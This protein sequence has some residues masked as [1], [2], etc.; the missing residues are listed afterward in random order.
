MKNHSVNT[1][2]GGSHNHKKQNNEEFAEP[3]NELVSSIIDT[4]V[5]I[6]EKIEESELRLFSNSAPLRSSEMDLK[7][8]QESVQDSNTGRQRRKVIFEDEQEIDQG[9]VFLSLF[10]PWDGNVSRTFPSLD[11][12][13]F[14]NFSIP[15]KEKISSQ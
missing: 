3:S 7:F 12:K 15:G 14:I 11:R 2:Q 6:D 1:N 4:G 5:T 13:I 9:Y 10:Q 8:K